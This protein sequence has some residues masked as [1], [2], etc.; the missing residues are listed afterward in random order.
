MQFY[1]IFI[2]HIQVSSK[3]RVL[4]QKHIRAILFNLHNL[5]T[6]NIDD[7]SV[8]LDVKSVYLSAIVIDGFD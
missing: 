6:F 4:C 8:T 5:L 2:I 3:E 1:L 7:L